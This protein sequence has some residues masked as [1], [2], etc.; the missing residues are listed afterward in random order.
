MP[1]LLV[2]AD[3]ESSQTLVLS[4]ELTPMLLADRH[5]RDQLVERLAWALEDAADAEAAD[6]P[7]APSTFAQRRTDVSVP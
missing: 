6:P 4:E 3:T 7:H 2:T 5:S 1:H